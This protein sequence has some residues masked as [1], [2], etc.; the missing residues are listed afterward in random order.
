[1]PDPTV[2]PPQ[3][4]SLNSALERNIAALERRRREDAARASLEER[5][6][7][8]ITRF[9]GSM[10]FVYLNLILVGL[11]VSINLGWIPVVPPFDPEFIILAM[12]ASV[13]AI[14][15]STFVLIAQNRMARTA[16]RRAELDLQ[17]SLLA[18][19]EVTRIVTLVS[20]IADR[21]GL[22]PGKDV[23]EL[24]R[25][26]APEAVLD[27]IDSTERKPRGELAE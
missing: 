15:L 1:M 17:I 5:I 20:A 4:A 23:E 13:A 14:F 9:T 27:A 7:E 24:K 18:E 6:A 3:P 11:W 12:I 26:V 16:D 21:L 22:E 8:A 2:T 25:D 19:H 10:L